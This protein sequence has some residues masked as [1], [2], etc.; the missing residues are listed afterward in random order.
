M[1]FYDS[2]A[3]KKMEIAWVLFFD[4]YHEYQTMMMM[5]ERFFCMQRIFDWVSELTARQ[6]FK[7]IAILSVIQYFKWIRREFI[8]SESF[9]NRYCWLSTLDPR[10]N[11]KTY[12]RE[13]N[14][15][16]CMNFRWRRWKLV[17]LCWDEQRGTISTNIKKIYATAPHIDIL[18]NWQRNA[19]DRE[20]SFC[21]NSE[22]GLKG[23][24][25]LFGDIIKNLLNGK[26]EA[27]QRKKINP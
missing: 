5:R 15:P 17:V 11:P 26:G 24:L 6:L 20:G 9:A 12:A 16:L 19:N 10:L 22:W 8:E 21:W 3:W 23:I 13:K 27:E 25:E 14:F 1:N 2:L 18:T 7:W 4:S